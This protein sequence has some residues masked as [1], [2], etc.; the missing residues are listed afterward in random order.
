MKLLSNRKIRHHEQGNYRANQKKRWM[1]GGEER[2]EMD[3]ERIWARL[4]QPSFA[5]WEGG[6]LRGW[7]AE[8]LAPPLPPPE[9]RPP[10]ETKENKE[11]PPR[12]TKETKRPGGMR[13]AIE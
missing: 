5:F 9:Y 8:A 11:R 7:W 10:R 1:G 2:L 6:G 13:D 3:S 12:E 4:L